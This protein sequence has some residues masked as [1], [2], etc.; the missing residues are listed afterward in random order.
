MPLHN[1]TDRS[2]WDG[3]H[4]LWITE[5]LRWVK[6]RLPA[7]YRAISTEIS[8]ETGAGGFILPNDRVDVILTKREKNPDS[9]GPDV[10]HSEIILTNV[11]VL[12]EKECL[13]LAI[14]NG[15]DQWEADIIGTF[16]RMDRLQERLGANYYLSE[17]W[18]KLHGAFHFSLVSACGSPNLLEIRHKLFER[19]HRYRRMSSQFRTQWRAK[20]VEHRMI[21][22]AV[23]ARDTPTSRP[24]ARAVTITSAWRSIP[25]ITG[26]SCTGRRSARPDRSRTEMNSSAVSPGSTAYAGSS[27]CGIA[28]LLCPH[29]TAHSAPYTSA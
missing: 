15:D 28:W 23:I 19:A 12:V 5:L 25:S 24:P 18:A 10:S 20:D 17:E 7:G 9:K 13:A 6:P 1:W 14:R 11:R 21:L 2:G 4:H 8:P 22:D 3:L 27:V 29:D 16:H 26:R